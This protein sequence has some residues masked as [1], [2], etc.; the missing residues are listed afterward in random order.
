[1]DVACSH[2]EFL[3]DSYAYVVNFFP[4]TPCDEV[5]PV[6]IYANLFESMDNQRRLNM[7]KWSGKSEIKLVRNLKRGI[8][9]TN[10][11]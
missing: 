7:I 3:S 2:T 10:D 6:S 9:L 4:F 1:M 11:Q 5:K 8:R